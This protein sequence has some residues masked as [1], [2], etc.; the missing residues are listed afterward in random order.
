MSDKLRLDIPNSLV[1]YV[2]EHESGRREIT[3]RIAEEEARDRV[4]KDREEREYKDRVQSDMEYA[5][6]ICDWVNTFRKSETGDQILEL[7]PRDCRPDRGLTFFEWRPRSQGY[8]LGTSDK[9]IRW[10]RFGPGSDQKYCNTSEELSRAANRETP[11]MLEA[12]YEAI[13]DGSV[14]K[15]IRDE[16]ERFKDKG[17]KI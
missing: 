8:S 3:G 17:L 6:H 10:Y 12:T 7:I 14:W 15:N 1:D 4:R 2:T 9:G 5:Q 16:L 11:G 13:K